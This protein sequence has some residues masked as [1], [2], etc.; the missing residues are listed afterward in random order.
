MAETTKKRGR[1]PD[2]NSKSGKIR[3]LLSTGMSAGDIAKKLGCTPALVYNVKAR[4]SGGSAK[5]RGPG[6]P[7]KAKAASGGGGLDGIAG[8]LDAVKNSERERASLRA[9]LEKIQAVI[10]DALA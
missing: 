10:S 7:P 9:A 8:I 4:L 5:K 6:R 1:K 3:E 2:A